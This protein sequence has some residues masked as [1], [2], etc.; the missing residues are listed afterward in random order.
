MVDQVFDVGRK[1]ERQQDD[2]LDGVQ[3]VEH[4]LTQKRRNVE[5]RTLRVDE[6][7]RRFDRHVIVVVGFVD[8]FFFVGGL[9]RHLVEPKIVVE[10]DRRQGVH[11]DVVNEFDVSA[12]VILSVNW[13]ICFSEIKI[14]GCE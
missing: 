2:V 10:V 14:V 6:F 5:A 7:G 1:A 9:R 13:Y 8:G 12:I 4:Q 11:R 3:A